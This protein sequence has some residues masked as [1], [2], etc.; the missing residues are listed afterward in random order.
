[1]KADIDAISKTS[2]YKLAQKR[3]DNKMMAQLEKDAMKATFPERQKLAQQ[4]LDLA[5]A[6]IALSTAVAMLKANK[7]FGWP[8]SILP[9]AMVA[10]IGTAQ[11][12]AAVA[13]NP[14]PTFAT[15]GDFVT[16]GPQNIMVGDNPGGRERVQVTP[17]SSPNVAGPQGGGSITVNVS[18]NL[19]SSE[20]VE[21]ELSDQI[22]EAIRRG[23]D[24]GIG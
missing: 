2:S 7:D 11:A 16:S 8:A 23:T 3:G 9:M 17:L 6:D 19:M 1:M 24:F 10:G 13:A 22:K 20:Y 14:I 12:S 5:I 21:E 4:S 18:G 15:G